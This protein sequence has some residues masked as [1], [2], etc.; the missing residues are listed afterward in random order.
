MRMMDHLVSCQLLKQDMAKEQRAARAHEMPGEV[1]QAVDALGTKLNASKG[2]G[3]PCDSV[4]R[5]SPVLQREDFGE[6]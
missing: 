5:S 6:F 1:G 3:N 4:G 2:H